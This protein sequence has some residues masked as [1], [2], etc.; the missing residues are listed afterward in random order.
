MEY[1]G[2]EIKEHKEYGF[3]V[4]GCVWGFPDVETMKEYIDTTDNIYPTE[5]KSMRYGMGEMMTSML[6]DLQPA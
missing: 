3:S 6:E 5:T 4:N 1:K 2:Y